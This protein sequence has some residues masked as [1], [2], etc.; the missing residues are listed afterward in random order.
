MDFVKKDCGNNRD[1][2]F[3]EIGFF[4]PYANVMLK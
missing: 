4:N 1:S 2:K 3:V